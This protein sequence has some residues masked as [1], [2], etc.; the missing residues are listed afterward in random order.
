MLRTASCVSVY[1]QSLHECTPHLEIIFQA[2]IS[3]FFPQ[4]LFSFL[5]LSF[6]SLLM[7]TTGFLAKFPSHA[8]FVIFSLQDFTQVAWWITHK[9]QNSWLHR[10]YISRIPTSLSRLRNFLPPDTRSFIS[11]YTSGRHL[12]HVTL[13]NLLLQRELHSKYYSLVCL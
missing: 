4:M 9:P 7:S 3:T 13:Y 5:M 1:L 8:L 11:L 2:H 6:Q 10:R 12:N